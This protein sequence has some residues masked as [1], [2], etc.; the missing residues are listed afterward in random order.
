MEIFSI[1]W[2]GWLKHLDK[3]LCDRGNFLV[4][5]FSSTKDTDIGFAPNFTLYHQGQ[6][7]R[8]PKAVVI[9]VIG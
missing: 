2:P 9:W 4:Q 8:L 3:C 6:L 7:K 5:N 1:P